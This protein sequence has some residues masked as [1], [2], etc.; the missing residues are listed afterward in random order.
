MVGYAYPAI[1]IL[2]DEYTALVPL[3]PEHGHELW[4]AAREGGPELF[5]HL[6]F[7]PFEHR[8][9]LQA[10]IEERSGQHE[11]PVFAIRSERLSAVVGSVQLKPVD[12]ING[13]TEISS[14]WVSP[15]TQGSEV[16][17]GFVRHVLRY[18]FEELGYRR[19]VWKCDATNI[20]SRHAAE[21]IGFTL[22]GV[23]RKH[24]F[25]RGRSRDTAWYA[26]VDSDWER[27]RTILN[28]RIDERAH[29]SE[30]R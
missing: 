13:S 17:P 18:L 10:W 27:V 2:Q 29:R 1:D 15:R 28:S 9:D 6:F 4:N 8:A 16:V 14:I 23:F 30:I 25:I 26:V 11:N 19:V 20:P 7:G 5:H 3:L 21:G 22:E 12:T 24:M